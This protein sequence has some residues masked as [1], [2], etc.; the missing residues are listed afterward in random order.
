MFLKQKGDK[1]IPV[2]L[3]KRKETYKK[4]KYWGLMPL[5]TYLLYEKE[6]NGESVSCCMMESEAERHDSD[7][8][9]SENV[10]TMGVVFI[11]GNQDNSR[12]HFLY[13]HI[14]WPKLLDN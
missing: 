10:M 6:Y 8:S 4:C 9:E 2:M 1:E 13:W 12:V 5:K 14:I 3:A 7:W 11:S